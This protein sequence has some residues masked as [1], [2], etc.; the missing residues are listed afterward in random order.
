MDR[1]QF[2]RELTEHYASYAGLRENTKNRSELIDKMNKWIGVPEG[3]PY[4]LTALLYGL[5]QV[6]QKHKLRVNLPRTA[7]TQLFAAQT[8]SLYKHQQ[9]REGDFA[10]YTSLL[11]FTRGHAGF[12]KST[13]PDSA[14]NYEFNT[15]IAGS[16]DG[17]GFYEK[18]R[19]FKGEGNLKLLTFIRVPNAV[20]FNGRPL[21]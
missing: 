15:N 8:S 10:I 1:R 16:R 21:T 7:G 6:A 4:C 19:P 9:P 11:N 17:D 2:V 13:G 18:T 3:S 14:H 20:L 12:V 5:H